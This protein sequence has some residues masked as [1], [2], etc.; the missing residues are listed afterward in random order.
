MRGPLVTIAI[1]VNNGADYLGEA[2]DSAL[3]QTYPNVEIVVVNDGSEDDGATDAVARRFGD[4]IRYIVQENRGVSGALNT[5]LRQMK[6]EVFTWLSHD[7]LFEPQKTARQVEL[8]QRA[9][10]RDDVALFSDFRWIGA[11]G[12]VLG[13]ECAAHAALVSN[14]MLAFYDGRIN[15]CTLFAPRDLMVS[16][17]GFDESLRYVQ[18]Y[19][20]WRALVGRAA[21]VHLPELLVRIR[22]HPAQGSRTFAARLEA[23]AFWSETLARV[24]E[25]QAGLVHGGRETMLR[26]TA[27]FLRY[28]S[29]NKRA[30]NAA[31]RQADAV[32]AQTS[33]SVL[34]DLGY[35]SSAVRRSAESVLAQTHGR[36]ELMLLGD[37]EQLE[38]LAEVRRDDRVLACPTTLRGAPARFRAGALVAAGAYVALLESGDLYAPH[39]IETQLRAMSNAGQLFC[40]TSYRMRTDGAVVRS[41]AFGGQ[42]YPEIL[43]GHPIAP[44]T[45]MAHRALVAQGLF[46]SAP[47]APLYLS[48]T[49]VAAR[50]PLLGLDQPLSEL[51]RSPELAPADLVGRL[52]ADPLHARHPYDLSRLEA[53]LAHRFEQALDP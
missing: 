20:A 21:L 2:I 19:H 8:H 4:R 16:I 22:A 17:G 29:P 43:G 38:P 50:H 44:S 27:D 14:P 12:A 26:R 7:D 3:A 34:L 52:R 13:E 31:R 11:D 28:R 32:I 53:R 15:G 10:S 24:G 49:D 33:V 1:P 46:L 42:A 39:K 40:H 9:G 6:G 45:V 23:E 35:D 37:D 51:A 48:W 5:A 30:A 36:L 47:E 25:V 41:G 18:D